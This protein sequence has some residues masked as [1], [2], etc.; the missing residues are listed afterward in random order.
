M[1][2]SIDLLCDK[3]VLGHLHREPVLDAFVGLVE[4]Q[5]VGICSPTLLEQ[6]ITAEDAASLD[7]MDE[8]LISRL[9]RVPVSDAAGKR[10]E[11]VQRQL[12]ASGHHRGIS[13]PDLLVAATAEEH[14][15]TVLHFD[16]DFET[17]AAITRQATRWL[18]EPDQLPQNQPIGRR[19]R[20]TGLQIWLDERPP[21][22]PDLYVP[23]L[24]CA[25]CR[26][27]IGDY[28]DG[29]LLYAVDAAWQVPVDRWVVV[30]KRCTRRWDQRHPAYR[31][32]SELGQS[33]IHLLRS[34]AVDEPERGR[35][36]L[37]DR[38]AHLP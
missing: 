4:E 5:R 21:G 31:M 18:L 33:V 1:E 24:V 8:V 30:H 10:A 29:N 25:E 38:A 28:H 23:G 26:S 19:P 16:R 37:S 15:L 11:R 17:I 9:E 7:R 12:V 35:F 2:L 32:S 3:S 20:D 13:V 22:E 36:D 34:L 6:Q 14:G 27:P